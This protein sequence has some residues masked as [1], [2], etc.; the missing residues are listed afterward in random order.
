MMGKVFL[1]AS[2]KIVNHTNREPLAEQQI[3]HVASDEAR[4][5]RDYCNSCMAH[6]AS[7]FLIVR[8]L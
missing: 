4:A 5:A 7:S 3:D 1:V 8:M 2:R 6:R